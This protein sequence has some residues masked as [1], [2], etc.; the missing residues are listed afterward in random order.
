MSSQTTYSIV[1]ISPDSRLG[2]RVSIGMFIFDSGQLMFK[3]SS[4]KLHGLKGALG[5]YWVPISKSL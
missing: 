4:Q 5:D 3:Y 2:D 1:Y